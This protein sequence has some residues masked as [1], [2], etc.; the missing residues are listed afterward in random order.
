MLLALS[1][2]KKRINCLNVDSSV[3]QDQKSSREPCGGFWHSTLASGRE[4]KAVSYVGAIFNSRETLMVAKCSSGCVNE[5]RK[6]VI[7]KKT[8]TKDP[9]RQPKT[10]ATGSERC[11]VEYY[12][13]FKSHR[14]VEMNI[15][16]APF[17]LAVRHGNRHQNK[18]I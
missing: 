12:K 8:V 4:T 7:V 16:D 6:H 2:K 14:P 18:N 1:S 17:F 11:P 15:A 13:T 3:C 9:F 5:A 10:Y